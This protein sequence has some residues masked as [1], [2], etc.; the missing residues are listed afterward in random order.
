MPEAEEATEGSELPS[1]MGLLES[2]TIP[3][4]ALLLPPL[5]KGVLGFRENLGNPKP[6]WGKEII[7]CKAQSMHDDATTPNVKW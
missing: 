4:P 7:V 2:S 3:S 6:K 5:P 1:P